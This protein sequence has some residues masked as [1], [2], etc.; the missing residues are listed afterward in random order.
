MRRITHAINT[1]ISSGRADHRCN[2]RHRVHRGDHIGAMRKAHHAHRVIEQSLQILRIEQTR[3][4]IN[5][6]FFH[7]NSPISQAPPRARIG[8]M[9]LVGDDDRLPRFQ[10]LPD[11]LCQNIGILGSGGSKTQLITLHAQHRGQALAGLIHFRSAQARRLIRRIGLYFALP[12]EPGQTIL[13]LYTG[14]R[15]PCVFEKGLPLQRRHVKGREILA[16]E[17]YIKL[18]G[19]GPQ[20]MVPRAIP[21]KHERRAA[22]R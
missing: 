3:L 21:T 13:N 8:F 12:I 19:V 11:R 6:P 5:A 1:R 9:V 22:L 18:H 10:P 17:L 16:D 4:R 14:V 2:F 15:S 20:Q 7:L